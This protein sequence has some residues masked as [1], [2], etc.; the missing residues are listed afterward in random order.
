VN[1]AELLDVQQL[2]TRTFELGLTP[3][4]VVTIEPPEDG[5]PGDYYVQVVAGGGHTELST[6]AV[7]M[8][9]LTGGSGADAGWLRDLVNT[10]LR[11]QGKPEISA[12]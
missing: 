9:V 3:F 12:A 7:L 6:I 2:S 8:E 4:V 1:I 5:E 10:S 11:A